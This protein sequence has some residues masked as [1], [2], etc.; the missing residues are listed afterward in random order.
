MGAAQRCVVLQRSCRC[1][2]VMD[3]S[4]FC[5]H[6]QRQVQNTRL[7]IIYLTI[8]T[9]RRCCLVACWGK[10]VGTLVLL[11][12][13][14]EASRRLARTYPFCQSLSVVHKAAKAPQTSAFYACPSLSRSLM[15]TTFWCVAA[16]E[17]QLSAIFCKL[18][19]QA[20]TLQV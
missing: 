15:R 9:C 5:I 8:P 2:L 13:D 6:L 20:V 10:L 11:A 4:R 1:A 18:Q 12:T 17:L 7:T 19:L 16:T 14:C 3:E